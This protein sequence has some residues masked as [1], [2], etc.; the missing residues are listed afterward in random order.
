MK[1][2]PVEIMR[3]W[4]YIREEGPNAG[5]EIEGLQR[6]AGGVKGDSYC[7]ESATVAL[8]ISFQGKSPIP[9]MR[10]CQSVYDLAIK[11]GWVVASNEPPK[12]ND[13]FLYVNDANHAHHIGFITEDGKWIGIA[14]NTSADGKS[15]NGTG[16]FE[17]EISNDRKH[18]ILVRYPMN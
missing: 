2:E 16:F 15:S 10:A 9:L 18:V 12:R 3:Q 6:W 5:N 14:G 4:L 11:K 1:Y 13:I 7:C 8:D 17:H